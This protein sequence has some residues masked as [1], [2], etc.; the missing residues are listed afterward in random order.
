MNPSPLRPPCLTLLPRCATWLGTVL[1]AVSALGTGPAWSAET[2]AVAVPVK[3]PALTAV[4]LP[5]KLAL[6]LD[7]EPGPA[8]PPPKVAQ[9]VPVAPAAPTPAA[10]LAPAAAA[11]SPASPTPA[12]TELAA[13]A[14][15]EPRRSIVGPGDL[16][17]ITVYGQPDMGAEVTVS[18]SGQIALPLIGTLRVGDLTPPSIEQ[19]IAK[20]LRDGEYL[21]NPGVSVQVRQFKSQMVSVLGEVQRPGRYPLEGKLTVLDALAV[22]G[23]TTP[24]AD[25]QALVL[26][27]SATE[28]ARQEI[29][30]DL[31]PLNSPS[32]GRLELALLPDDVVFV[33][34]QK[35][36]YVHGE[37]RKPGAYPMEPELN[38]LRVLSISGGVSDR[39]SV[40][41]VTVH[42][43]DAQNRLQALP[44][45]PDTA[46]LP[47]D[48]I[49][50]DERFF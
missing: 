12:P 30:V 23:G 49:F 27:R 7:T 28:P 37:V 10:T 31:D 1:L 11:G 20:R 2:A 16:L 38:L 42:R 26:R 45:E 18:D 48:V 41:R 36:F 39:G 5:P 29:T 15:A 14:S 24:R 9:A 8:L 4:S 33:G 19:A 22:A 21:V 43:R 17:T 34:P 3:S 25:R 44:A 6:A 46:I 32:R 40:N 13:P 50:V 47:G 35:L